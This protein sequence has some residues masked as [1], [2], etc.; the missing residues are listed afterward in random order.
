MPADHDGVVAQ[1]DENFCHQGTKAP[2]NTKIQVFSSRSFAFLA[3]IFMVGQFFDNY[4]GSCLK[5]PG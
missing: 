5:N 2:R 4:I 3:A 1:D